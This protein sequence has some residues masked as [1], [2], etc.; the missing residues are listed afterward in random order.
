[1][2]S[3]YTRCSAC[4]SSKAARSCCNLTF[5]LRDVVHWH[6]DAVNLQDETF[7]RSR[8]IY[9]TFVCRSIAQLHSS[10][11]PTQL[12]KAGDVDVRIPAIAYSTQC[13]PATSCSRS[14]TSISHDLHSPDMFCRLVYV[15]L[16][17]PCIMM[18]VSHEYNLNRST[19]QVLTW[20][21]IS[22]YST[23][24]GNIP[25]RRETCAVDRGAS[26]SLSANKDRDRGN[27]ACRSSN[28]YLHHWASMDD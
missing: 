10:D 12:T 9:R 16:P 6:T 21:D 27:I 20:L 2:R 19:R 24:L 22:C 7:L 14:K 23:T 11:R 5:S 15:Q 13:A 17:N 3:Y 18:P 8:R 25:C 4:E 28:I 26:P 1:M